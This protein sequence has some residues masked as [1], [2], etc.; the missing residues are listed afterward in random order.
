MENAEWSSSDF[1][2]VIVSYDELTD[3]WSY[4][5]NDISG[6]A[7]TKEE[8]VQQVW[9]LINNWENDVSKSE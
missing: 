8:L 9:E 4:T 1:I 2:P 7:D 5:V 6:I 3:M